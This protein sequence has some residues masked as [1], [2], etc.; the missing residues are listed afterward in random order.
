MTAYAVGHLQDVD[1]CDDI[2]EYLKRIDATLAP[3]GGRFAVH[4]AKADVVEGEWRG[5]LVVIAFDDMTHA[6]GWYDSAAYRRILPL[7]TKHARS[8]VLLIEG[9]DATHRATDILGTAR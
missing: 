3:F 7:R 1:F 8:A 5:D 2:V 9:V 6:R 4:G